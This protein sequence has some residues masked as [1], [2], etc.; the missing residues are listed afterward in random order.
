[1]ATKTKAP[2]QLC[3]DCKHFR[4]NSYLTDSGFLAGC[5]RFIT[6]KTKPDVVN[7][8]TSKSVYIGGDCHKVR[9]VRGGCGPKGKYFEQKLNP[10]KKEPEDF[11][12]FLETAVAD[13]A[14]KLSPDECKGINLV[15]GDPIRF[16]VNVALG[17]FHRDDHHDKFIEYSNREEWTK[18]RTIRIRIHHLAITVKI[19]SRYV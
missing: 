9:G 1:M 10:T 13:Q 16:L 4:S 6:K 2:L 5:N 12:G 8:S 14:R 19:G 7:G 3:R 15:G 18:V 11:R 17:P